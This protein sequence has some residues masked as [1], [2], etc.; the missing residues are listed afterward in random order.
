LDHLMREISQY[1]A[2]FANAPST[3]MRH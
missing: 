1:E 3:D 2:E